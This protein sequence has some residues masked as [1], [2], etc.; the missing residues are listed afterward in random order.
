LTLNEAK[1]ALEKAVSLGLAKLDIL[2]GEP[3]TCSYLPDFVR[4][5]K[6]RAKHGFCGVVSNGTLLDFELAQKLASAGLDQIS[7]SLDGSC[8]ETNDAHRGNGV[9]ERATVGIRNAIRAKLPVTIAFTVT[10]FNLQETHDM[11]FAAKRLG[12]SSVGIQIAEPTGRGRYSLA[13]AGQFSRIE[14]L[15]AICQMYHVRAPLYTEM[16]SRYLFQEF[17]NKFFNAGLKISAGICDGGLKAYM[18]SSGGDLFPCAEYAYFP[19]GRARGK[20]ANL[21]SWDTGS[22]VSYVQ[23]TGYKF[24]IEMVEKAGMTFE[25][26]RRCAHK[27]ECIPCPLQNLSSTI[28]ECEWVKDAER[29]LTDRILSSI[30]ALLIEP[31]A[32]DS[33]SLRFGVRTQEVPLC[34]PMGKEDFMDI[35]LSRSV[36]RDDRESWRG[37]Y[38]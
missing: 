24:N 15:K 20:G 34:V 1:N 7:I 37:L 13:R 11:L 16:S 27:Q 9:F 10:Q 12:A 17:L 38:N 29:E 18:V 19:D 4:H 2:G 21:V 25:S 14:G 3:L 36:I 35:I 32:I 5:F 22:L 23:D 8:S 33:R 26:C 31:E 6:A 28:K 30:M